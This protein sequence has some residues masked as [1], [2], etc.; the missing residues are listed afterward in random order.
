M[1]YT[2]KQVIDE[3]TSPF[4]SK[5]QRRCL[6]GMIPK[7]KNCLVIFFYKNGFLQIAEDEFI[8]YDKYDYTYKKRN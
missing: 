3:L 4:A 8:K 5:R 6:L 7:S 2:T 1:T